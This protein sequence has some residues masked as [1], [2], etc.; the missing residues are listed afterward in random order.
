M[1][2]HWTVFEGMPNRVSGDRL[3]VTLNPRGVL[4]LNKL[5]FDALDGPAAV[6]LMFDESNNLIGL[7]PEDPRRANAFPVKQKDRWH[8]RQV[9]ASPF[10]RH[11]AI[12]VGRTVLFN[13]VDIDN[14]GVMVLELGKTI[15]VGR[16]PG[17]RAR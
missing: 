17:R 12:N 3:R 7:K 5:A 10:C 6:K 8:N 13:D 4:V 9:H 2:K 11:F 15:T 1:I 14:D 16:G